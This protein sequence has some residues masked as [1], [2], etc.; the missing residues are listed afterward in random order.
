MHGRMTAYYQCADNVPQ[1][2]LLAVGISSVRAFVD[3]NKRTAYA[4]AD[5]FLRLN[6]MAFIGHPVELT[7]QLEAVAARE[8][9]LDDA[10]TAFEVWLR[11]C[12]RIHRMTKTDD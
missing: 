10:T 5:I 6:A 12:I 4:S 8:G 11:G 3:G 9:S 2:A 1:A 7:Q